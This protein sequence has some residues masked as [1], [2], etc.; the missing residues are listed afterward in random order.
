M[1]SFVIPVYNDGATAGNMIKEIA[2]VMDDS[3][4]GYEILIID[5]GSTR[6]IPGK[7]GAVPGARII[8]HAVNRGE[9]AAR[10]TGVLAAKGDFI[11]MIDA[12]GTYSCA[13]IPKLLKLRETADMVVG[14]RSDDFGDLKPL[15]LAVKFLLRKLACFLAKAEIADLNSGLR[16]MR[17]EV[18]L[19]YLYILPDTH[20]W[21]T[22]I[23]MSMLY[24]G[25]RVVYVPVSYGKRIGRSTFRPV[26][27]TLNLCKALVRTTR[28]FRGRKTR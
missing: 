14:A 19:R 5:D 8:R 1:I 25:H 11:L 20:S 23:T 10:T 22:T 27:D 12:D 15:R 3:G 28:A 18:L 21:V 16:L 13:D 7:E 24:N 26:S 17:K 4:L 6:D 9:G 2:A